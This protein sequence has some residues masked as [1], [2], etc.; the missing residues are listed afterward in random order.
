MIDAAFPA[1]VFAGRRRRIAERLGRG[2]MV[3]G[4]APH[5]IKSGDTTYRYRADS[6]LFYVTG[7]ASADTAAVL[8]PFAD[9]DRFVLF[10]PEKDPVAELWT[11]HRM[12][13]EEAKERFQADR[14]YPIGELAERLPEL[15]RASDSISYRMG[16]DTAI[17]RTVLDALRTGRRIWARHGMGPRT[18]SDPG[19]IL[20]EMRLVKDSYEIAAIR[21][22]AAL[23]C[24]SFRKAL[25]AVKHANGEWEIEAELEYRFRRGGG[26]GP[27]FAT[28]AACGENA[29]TLHYEDN[30]S[31]LT[32]T[33][34]LL[35]D[36]GAELGMYCAD[37][38]RTVPVSG[39]FTAGQRAIHDLV[40]AALSAG[41]SAVRPG[42]SVQNVHDVTVRTLSQGLVD[43]GIM[44]GPV[45]DVVE[46]NRYRDLYPHRTSHWLGLDV[47]DVGDYRVSG[48]DRRLT[49][50]MVL[51]VEPGLYF[52]AAAASHTGA[53]PFIG[54]G[55]RLED[56]ILVTEDGHENLTESLPVSAAEWQ[57]FGE[58]A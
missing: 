51:T 28:I 15:L 6:E 26:F 58:L 48:E 55:V 39:R 27:A 35:L 57:D 25:G 10:V 20:D 43:L 32:P 52:G 54:I 5:R 17:D 12:S 34:L 19:I 50:G 31:P 40:Y 3:L 47:H 21:R 41:I 49:P 18:V 14:V 53:K 1:E 37:V 33:D 22:A 4:A 16:A 11:G 7:V 24:D 29:C 56:D 30:R 44:D 23:T 8:R 46:Q 9:E 38:T 2:A 13:P 45:D 42:G 36:G